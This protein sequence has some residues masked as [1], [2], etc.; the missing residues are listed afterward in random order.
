MHSTSL[1]L[2]LFRRHMM[3]L[4]LMLPS[5]CT[6]WK[7]AM[8]HIVLLQLAKCSYIEKTFLLHLLDVL[9]EMLGFACRE[10]PFRWPIVVFSFD[11]SML[12][13]KRGTI[14]QDSTTTSTLILQHSEGYV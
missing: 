4:A 2:S 10:L 8:L 5:K 6:L 7:L 9:T 11:T 14:E 3:L 12:L 13:L 1:I